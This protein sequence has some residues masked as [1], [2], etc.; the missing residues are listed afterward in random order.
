MTAG[1]DEAARIA[2]GDQAL[3]DDA[4]ARLKA[5]GTIE[6]RGEF[7]NEITTFIPFV[8][9][10]KHEGLLAGR[11]VVTYR[12]MR[13]YYFFLDDGEYDEKTGERHWLPPPQRDWP[14]SNSYTAT[15]QN[16]HVMPDYRARY[17]DEGRR[18]ERPLLFIQNK[19]CVEWNS[20]PINY[21]PLYALQEIFALAGRRF[22]IVYSRPRRMGGG[23]Y[24]ADHA[25]DCDYPDLAI[26]RRFPEVIVLED[27]VA[28]ARVPYNLAKLQILAKCWLSIAV[29]GGGAHLLACFGGGVMLL[30]HREGPEHPHAYAAGP[31]KYL[32][33]PPPILLVAHDYQQFS[34]GVELLTNFRWDGERLTIG[35]A[36]RPILDKLRV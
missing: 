35:E 22:D 20:G 17:R 4:L 27:Y 2:V 32:A 33:S 15:R 36:W 1:G 31:Y 11:R 24:T 6:Y 10:L 23:D 28:Q 12:G 9:W 30:L 34:R 18:F 25:H 5:T 19:F 8:H 14:S 13:P 26:A 7:G 29:Q 21:L 16:W 3:L